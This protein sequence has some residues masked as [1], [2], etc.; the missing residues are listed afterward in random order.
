MGSFF[1]HVV[2]YICNVKPKRI[3]MEELLEGKGQHQQGC[4]SH[5]YG[6]RG[7]R[8]RVVGHPTEVSRE[9]D[10]DFLAACCRVKREMWREGEFITAEAIVARVLAGGA[11]S[12]YITYERAYRNLMAM[13][14]CG[15][16]LAP[17]YAVR[18]YSRRDMMLEIAARCVAK[19]E[20][21]KRVLPRHP[22]LSEMSLAQA[23]THVL[24]EGNASSFFVS[25]KYAR[26]LYF[27]LQSGSKTIKKISA[28]T[29]NKQNK[30]NKQ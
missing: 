6:R 16:L 3:I 11:P 2:W 12:Y 1:A 25:R 17:D 10:A 14:K 4:A 5:R 8:G 24:A 15:K 29:N 27:Q 13:V 9:R 19:M 23:L 18:H 30:Q 26:L 20:E 22:S 7:L 21:R 28:S